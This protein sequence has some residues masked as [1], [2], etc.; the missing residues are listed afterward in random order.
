VILLLWVGLVIGW[1]SLGALGSSLGRY[2]L[3]DETPTLTIADRVFLI[4]TALLFGPT[5]I[6]AVVIVWRFKLGR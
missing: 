4:T 3:M 5:N 2:L 1:L 6:I